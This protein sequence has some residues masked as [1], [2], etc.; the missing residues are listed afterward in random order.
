M[1]SIFY[2]AHFGRALVAIA[3]FFI[4]CEHDGGSDPA[5][6]VDVTG[7]WRAKP[8]RKVVITMALNQ[9]GAA[10]TGTAQGGDEQGN[11]TGKVSGNTFFFSVDWPITGTMIGSG[12]VE[13]NTLDGTITIDGITEPFIATRR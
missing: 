13:G 12:T 5:P 6:T 2:A 10:V 3:G 8:S 7:N 1:R 4:G 11:V 9:D